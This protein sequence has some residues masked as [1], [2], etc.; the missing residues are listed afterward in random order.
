LP[1][2]ILAGRKRIP[3]IK[4][5]TPSTAKP[6]IR[7]GIR[8]SHTIGYKNN[9]IIASGQQRKNK[10]SHNINLIIINFLYVNYKYPVFIFI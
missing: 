8:I 7:N 3:L 10:R 5:K 1:L 6:K 9:A 4:L 2:N